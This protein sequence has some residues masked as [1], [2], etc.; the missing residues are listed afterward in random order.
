[1]QGWTATWRHG[2]TRKR[3]TKRLKHTENLLS[4][5]KLKALPFPKDYSTGK[6]FNEERE[7]P[8]TP[9]KYLYVT[10]NFS[11]NRSAANPQCI[12]H[13]FDWIQRNVVASLVHFA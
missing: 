11:D 6:H 1:M 2:V 8:I 12:F 9:S 7:I 5:P 3:S 13:A 10:Q 4:E